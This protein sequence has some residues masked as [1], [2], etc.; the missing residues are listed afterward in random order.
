MILVENLIKTLKKNKIDFF[1]GVPDSI[2]KNFSLR[3]AN[4]SKKKHVIATNEGSAISLG[5]GYHLSTKNIPCIYLQNS[6]LSNAINPLISIAS[7]EVYSIPLFLIIGWRG[8]PNKPDEPQHKAKGKIT[9]ELLKLLK[10]K[11]CVLRNEK[12]LLKINMLVKNSKKNKNI[13]ACLI[14]KETLQLK[15][16]KNKII[17]SKFGLRSN[18]IRKFLS[19]IP[20]GCKII[21]TTGY[22]SREL[23]EIRKEFKKS[24]SKGKD[25][26]M[27]GGMGHSASVATGYALNSNK[28][29][30]CLD[31]DGSALMHLGSLRTAG[32]LKNS[33]YKHIILNNNAHESVGGQTTTAAGIDFLKLSK[34]I[35]Y[36]K[37]FKINNKNNFEK[38]IKKFVKSRG[39]SL[40]EVRIAS[41]SMKNLSRP[42]DLIQIKKKFMAN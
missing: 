36:K 9:K 1:T 19:L 28:Q 27:V 32:Y 18:F 4:L 41:K 39:P 2:L 38:T 14:E 6:G 21:S 12:D 3:I 5:I 7:R 22:T 25:F 30:F 31:G 26:Y 10:I 40:L 11:F 33:N 37:Y 15:K 20:N 24:K 34:S 35:G 42:K 8:S 23:M 13:V 16:K 17:I 29:I